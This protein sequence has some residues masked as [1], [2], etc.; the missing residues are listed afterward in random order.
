MSPSRIIA[1]LGSWWLTAFLLLSLWAVYL[2]FSF[3]RNPY[4]AWIELLFHAPAGIVI[5]ITLII[6]LLAASIRIALGRL[7]RPP[8]SP[9]YIRSLDIHAVIPIAG[10]ETINETAGLFGM[11]G[12]P[13]LI[14]QQGRRRVTGTWSFLPGTVFRAGLV[15]V[16]IS[17]MITAHS[18][19]THDASLRAGEDRDLLGARVSLSAITADLPADHLQ[20]GDDGTF[21]LPGVSARIEVDGKTAVVTPGFPTGINGRWYRIRHL[22]YSQALT[23]V[24]HGS[25]NDVV[26]DLDLL[27]PG[28]SSVVSLPTG[29]AFLTFTL[30]PDRTITKGLLT[31]RQ[32]NL[33][34]PAYRV[35][36]Q[37]GKP[38]EK[39]DSRRLLPGERASVGPAQISLGDQGLLIRLQA[40]SD[41]GLLPLYAG[42]VIMLTGLCALC[43]RFFWYEQEAA[44]V[45]HGNEILA[46]TRDEF[47]KKWG[48]ERFQRRSDAL[49]NRS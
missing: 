4:P 13:A 43:S 28:R 23:V 16:L 1:R 49:I 22:G 32:Y 48:I 44:L 39:A 14:R 45:V 18:R 17:L 37:E 31:G 33:V 42:V 11:T 36:V 26:A 3:G 19:R 5:Y 6:N 34:K 20:V 2:L 7:R 15:L 12:S 38:R 25:K 46:G 47:Y 35:T 41:P 30:D 21:L 24:V 8:L 9:D 29:S 40:V 27:P 10:E